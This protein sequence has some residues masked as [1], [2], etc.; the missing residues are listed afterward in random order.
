MNSH[1]ILLFSGLAMLSACGEPRLPPGEYKLGLHDA[2][3][4]LGMS[5]NEMMCRK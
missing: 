2:Y 5:A 3:E 4:R 1:K